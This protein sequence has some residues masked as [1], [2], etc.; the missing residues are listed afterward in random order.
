M[1]ETST[2]EL[3]GQLTREGSELP[4]AVIA[5]LETIIRKPALL[6][7]VIG[8]LLLRQEDP[9]N[10]EVFLKAFNHLDASSISLLQLIKIARKHQLRINIIAWWK[11]DGVLYRKF[12]SMSLQEQFKFLESCLP[13]LVDDVANRQEIPLVTLLSWLSLPRD[14]QAY[15]LAN[16]FSAQDK[17]KRV[18]INQ[19]T[20]EEYA[21]LLAAVRSLSIEYLPSAAPIM[22]EAIIDAKR[23][24]P[25]NEAVFI[26]LR[27]L[28]FSV[29]TANALIN[30]GY[31]LLGEVA[32]RSEAELLKL[33]FFGRQSLEEVKRTLQQ[34]GLYLSMKL[35]EEVKARM[36]KGDFKLSAYDT[37]RRSWN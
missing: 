5:L 9:E 27:T 32:E 10:P 11:S 1:S 28:P 23:E 29:R 25:V 30:Q 8:E 21:A 6:T 17:A 24:E 31:T 7:E 15:Q 4:P 19:V 26:D 33:K 3:I 36:E 12:S 35:S 34:F 13:H 18:L 37:R 20:L 16:M 2:E 22:E 14:C